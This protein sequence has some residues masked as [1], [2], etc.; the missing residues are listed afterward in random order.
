MKDK[1]KKK[2]VAVIISIGPK[3]PK[4][5][6]DAATPD[7]KKYGS[8]PMK[9]SWQTLKALPEHQM[10]EPAYE[11]ANLAETTYRGEGPDVGERQEGAGTIHP[12]IYAMMQRR[13]KENPHLTSG[14]YND[15]NADLPNLNLRANESFPDYRGGKTPTLD[16]HPEYYADS[17]PYGSRDDPMSQ[18]DAYANK[19]NQRRTKAPQSYS[20]QQTHPTNKEVQDFK[21]DYAPSLQDALKNTELGRRAASEAK[22]QKLIN[23]KMLHRIPSRSKPMQKAFGMLK[24]NYTRDSMPPPSRYDDEGFPEYDGEDLG[25]PYGK[26]EF[27][28]EDARQAEMN[29]A[30]RAAIMAEGMPE[31]RKPR[32]AP[33]PGDPRFADPNKPRPRM[34]KDVFANR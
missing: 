1:K 2:G 8:M 31:M 22:L 13:M 11:R 14:S 17:M 34:P 25:P 3:M 15:E 4:K 24:Q 6:M 21:D 28:D 19:D 23:S 33:R 5:P 16:M 10:F 32:G 27:G 30:E 9:K 7:M 26:P 29:E 18:F 20:Y 12:A